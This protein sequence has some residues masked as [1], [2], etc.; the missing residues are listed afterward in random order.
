MKAMRL[1]GLAAISLSAG[2]AG[3]VWIGADGQASAQ[4]SLTTFTI[5]DSAEAWYQS[6]PVANCSGPTGCPPFTPPQTYPAGTLHV[7]ELGGSETARTYLDLDLA[8]LPAG[9]SAVSGTLSLPVSVTSG[10]GNLDVGGADVSV[11]L[12][13]APFDDGVSGSASSP[14]GADC[15]LE[16]PAVHHAPSSPGG[17]ETFTA[18]LT[19]FLASWNAGTPDFGLVL[20]P[21][22]G[23][24]ASSA[25]HVALN[26]RQLSGVPHIS[27]SVAVSGY[28]PG[29][30]P[31]SVPVSSLPA[32]GASTLPG[33]ASPAPSAPPPSSLRAGPPSS[34]NNFASTGR[35][36]ASAGGPA[37]NLANPSQSV[38]SS[39]PSPAVSSSA[40]ARQTSSLPWPILWFPLV[41]AAAVAFTVRTFINPVFQESRVE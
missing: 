7:G 4:S 30:T 33:A 1:L 13:A 26:G 10:S 6:T 5:G 36:S 14:P 40:A 8:S 24:Q 16:I 17:A 15:T 9:T 27:A 20:V 28:K 38:P 25:W 35:P 32:G 34:S 11:C 29:T 21:L 37:T 22:Q 18:D 12:A 31:P 19:P 23:E 41:L 2:A 39:S 3:S